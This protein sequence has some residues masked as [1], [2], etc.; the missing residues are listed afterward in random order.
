[1]TSRRRFLHAAAV[2]VAGATGV[3]AQAPAKV[4][5]V[6]Y[7]NP[8]AGPG[9]AD[10]AFVRGMRELGYVEGRNLVI[11][12]RWAANDFTR[13][14]PLADELAR[15]PVDVFVTA[16][17]PGITAAMRAPG[18]IPVV[19]CA[20]ADPVRTGF[21]AS[22]GKPGGVVTGMT[23]QSNDL[24]RKRLQLVREIVP[25]AGRVGVLTL[26]IPD[27]AA[28]VNRLPRD[29]LM[30]EMDDAARR[31]G[32]TLVAVE[33]GDAGELPGAFE[34]LQR[35]PVQAVFVQANPLTLQYTR[36]VAELAAAH[37]LPALYELRSF[38]EAGGL[39]AYGP[40]LVEMYRRAASFVDRIFR[41]AQ[42][43]D[44]PIEQ[45]EK[46]ELVINLKAAQTLGLAIPQ[47]VLLRADEVIG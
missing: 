11:E 3:A 2:A 20:V 23:M 41:G 13:M 26:R 21:A 4:W 24:A 34:R 22:L 14:Q 39:V 29:A 31:L 18:R 33:A 46:L 44:L 28:D 40:D 37:R 17:T 42:P 43:G 8:R 27:G 32:V 25:G 38:A 15:L 45:P 16:S 5:R 9:P 47:P 7:L 6:G 35:A 12:Y 1:V 30:V 19:V 10:A 36:R